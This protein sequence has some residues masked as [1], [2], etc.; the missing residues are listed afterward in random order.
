MNLRV[1]GEDGHERPFKALPGGA[2][3]CFCTR[4]LNACALRRN[5]TK[6]RPRVQ[7]ECHSSPNTED[8][9]LPFGFRLVEGARQISG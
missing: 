8:D 5:P 6:Y 9:F 2:R 1:R 7:G 3:S 4:Y